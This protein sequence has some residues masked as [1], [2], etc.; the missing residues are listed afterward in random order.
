MYERETH[1]ALEKAVSG[2]D[3]RVFPKVRVADALDI[4]S[5]GLSDA[6]YR[7]ALA[8]HF[9]FVVAEGT[10][11]VRFAVEFDG[12][13]HERDSTVLGK[14][15]QKNRICERLGMPLLRIN[16]AF[17][18]RMREFSIVEWLAECWFMY[19]SFIHAQ[20]QGLI[21]LGV[22]FSPTD[23]LG[24]ARMESERAVQWENPDLTEL[25]EAL[26]RGQAFVD[27]PY[28]LALP[29][30]QALLAY[31]RRGLVESVCPEYWGHITDPSGYAP[32]LA[33]IHLTDGRF[34]MAESRCRDFNFPP[35]GPWELAEELAT[36]D[37]V[38]RLK[39]MLRGDS[40]ATSKPDVDRARSRM[41]KL[42][43]ICDGYVPPP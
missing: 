22:D 11:A 15:A 25:S 16:A 27:E 24:W 17:L 13:F 32:C 23:L 8:A 4:T 12:A 19:E 31:E 33:V 2:T 20:E 28:N 3:R 35:V 26:Q 18:R 21:P 7:Y 39:G 37:A 38:T 10:D 34:V 43:A 36:I 40:P 6:D 9:D 41:A 30:R 42:G 14:D 29:E 1:A 5:S